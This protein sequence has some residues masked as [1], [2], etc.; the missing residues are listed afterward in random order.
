MSKLRQV[1]GVAGGLLGAAAAGTAV[2]IAAQSAKIARVRRS[3]V[4]DPLLDE[5]LGELVPDRECTVAADD[6]VPLSVEEILPAD[7]GAPELTVV[8]AHGYT[9]DRRSW[10]FQR[11]DLPG[12]TSPRVRLVLYDHRSH[13][14]SGRSRRDACTIDQLGRDLAAVIR[15]L[16]PKGQ[17]VLV[18]HSMG[19]MTIMAL[20]DQQPELFAER[21]RGVAFV[22]TSAGRI[23]SSGLTQPVLSRYNPV[24]YSLAR[25][26]RWQPGLIEWVRGVGDH[27]AWG[28][29]RAFAFGDEEVSP[30]L[31][32]LMDRMISATPIRVITDFLPTLGTHDRF[33][34][35]R[36]L[37]HCHVLVIG[38]DH[39]KLTPFEH[40]E[41]IVEILPDAELVV[42]PGAGHMAMLEQPTLITEAIIELTRVCERPKGAPR[43]RW[44][45]AN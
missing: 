14:R 23:G 6:G 38:G 36:G 24:T 17:L 32:D 18:G 29:T 42:V 20:A 41:A 45:K 22:N 2:G 15:S 8:L 16:A 25:L 39:D 43:R 35:L 44:R 10:H 9:L 33:A 1:A 28:M 27:V 34:A 4:E 5:P 13:G 37:Q 31:V 11:R 7:G 30:A 40:S 19:G 3:T 12:L 21:V 26:A